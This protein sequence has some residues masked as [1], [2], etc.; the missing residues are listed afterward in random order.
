MNTQNYSKDTGP[1]KASF[2]DTFSAAVQ[3]SD[4]V[5]WCHLQDIPAIGSFFTW[6]NKEGVESRVY[7]RIDRMLVNGDWIS[8]YPEAFANFLPEGLYDH[9]PCI[10]QF[11]ALTRRNRAPFKYYNIWSLS[12]EFE[13]IV[14]EAWTEHIHEAKMFQVVSKLKMLK[15]RLRILNKR[16]FSD[17][18]NNCSITCMALTDVNKKLRV[19]P[20]D[21]ELIAIEMEIAKDYAQLQKAKHMFLLQK[22]KTEWATEGDDNTSYFHANV[23]D[24]H[25]PTVRRGKVVTDAMHSILHKQTKAPGPDGY[26]SQFF[27]DSWDVIG[28]GITDA[29][30]DLFQNGR[31]LKQLNNTLLTLIAKVDRPTSVTQFRPI[32]YCKTLYKC[33]AKI[34][35]TR[36]GEVLPM[37]I[38]PN[39]SAFIK[40][41]DIDENIMICQD[42]VR[43]Y[44]RKACSPRVMI[45]V[46][47]QKAYDSIEWLFLKQMLKALC[48][49]ARFVQL[50]MECVCTPSFSLALN[51]DFFGFFKAKRGIR[52]GDPLSPLLFIVCME[53]L[54]RVLFVVQEME[55]FKFHP[56]C[57]PL[58]LSH[59][60]FADEL[61]LFRKG[62]KDVVIMFL[63][64][65][66]TF[67]RASGLCMNQS[68]SSLYS[69]GVSNEVVSEIV[70]LTCMLEGHLPFRYLSVP[71]ASKRLSALECAKLVDKGKES[72][73]S[74]PLIAWSTCCKSKKEGGLGV[75][76]LRRWN[77]AALGHFKRF[78]GQWWLK[79]G[80][81]Y[82]IQQGYQWMG[83]P[84]DSKVW[85]KFVWNNLSLPKHCFIGWLVS[86]ERLLIKDRLQHFHLTSD[87]VCHLCGMEDEDHRHLFFR[88]VFS[89]R[90]VQVLSF[91]LD[92]SIPTT[93]VIQWWLKLRIRS[94]FKKKLIAALIQGLAY[95][96]WE[97]RNR[98]RFESVVSR[99]K[100]IVTQLR[101]EVYNRIVHLC[102]ATDRERIRQWLR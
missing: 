61:P 93:N 78:H 3:R 31:M 92:V 80:K 95:K 88:C 69:N 96:I 2:M 100:V 23:L 47:L 66:E 28:G 46:D 85:A 52:Q 1:S 89:N 79:E 65:F 15:M 40:G 75:I 90:C 94:L 97:A 63:R 16:D 45:K 8:C 84:D 76:D 21:P 43:L 71:I 99:P 48:F 72:A 91:R 39:Q 77:R 53:Y 7:S 17:I 73:N 86:N 4:C 29:V 10:V 83:V 37:I 67:S 12:S 70:H 6:N 101:E 32:T 14:R 24:V 59:L 13:G 102:K 38:S 64:A 27:K 87:S 55:G 74:P 81:S 62:E 98:C 20:I 11:D 33:I 51:G 57:K 49:P 30:L 25:V 26:T 22:S 58:K 56:L 50:I 35:S 44:G 18:E 60:Y 68:K 41:C 5:N 36:L 82:S 34:L 54:S 19:K 9:C 42:L